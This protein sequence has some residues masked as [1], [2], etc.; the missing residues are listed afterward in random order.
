MTAIQRGSEALDRLP[1]VGRWLHYADAA[2]DAMAREHAG[3]SGE[4]YLNALVRE[5]VLA[6]LDN[7]LTHPT[8]AMGIEAKQ[9]RVHGWVYDMSSGVVETYDAQAGRFVPISSASFVSATPAT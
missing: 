8:V 2:R 1:A 9:L 3:L 7:L 6:Q 4:E 5:N